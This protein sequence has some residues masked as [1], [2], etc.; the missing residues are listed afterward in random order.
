[1]YP[2][3]FYREVTWR[4]H[5]S[6]IY[7]VFVKDGTKC[8]CMLMIYAYRKCSESHIAGFL[9]CVLMIYACIKCS[10]S[11]MAGFLCGILCTS[12]YGCIFVCS[13]VQWG[14]VT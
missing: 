12:A 8:V 2:S 1:M 4:F 10:E 6:D 13:V 9:V 5:V 14:G 11:H 7:D 3:F